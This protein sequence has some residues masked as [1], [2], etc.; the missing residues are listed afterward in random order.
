MSTS[1]AGGID[2]LVTL[3]SASSGKTREAAAMALYYMG[4][5]SP[6]FCSE[7]FTSLCNTMLHA[8][9]EAAVLAA[10]D[11]LYMGGASEGLAATYL[12]NVSVKM[13]LKSS[14]SVIGVHGL[15]EASDI[16]LFS[17]L[18]KPA[19]PTEVAGNCVAA[20]CVD[21]NSSAVPRRWQEREMMAT[22]ML[23]PVHA[24]AI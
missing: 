3:L 14:V 15:M 9:G 19:G 8:H 12:T 13:L 17:Q 7:T 20:A 5:A 16:H 24:T 1:F 22:V 11:L 2:R 21:G 6:A 23:M 10:L 18:V 4:M